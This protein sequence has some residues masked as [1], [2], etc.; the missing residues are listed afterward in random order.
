MHYKKTGYDDETKLYNKDIKEAFLKQFEGNTLDTMRGTLKLLAKAERDFD[1]DMCEMNPDEFSETLRVFKCKTLKSMITRFSALCSYGEWCF[2]GYT[3]GRTPAT[4]EFSQDDLLKYIHHV[5][6]FMS[7]EEVYNEFGKVSINAQ[8]LASALLSWEGVKGQRNCELT[9]LKRQD[10]HPL[11]N[12]IDCRDENDE[13]I[14]HVIVRDT[15]MKVVIEAMNQ[16]EYKTKRVGKESGEPIFY[17]LPYNGFVFRQQT[18]EGDKRNREDTDPITWSRVNARIKNLAIDAG[19]PF[20]TTSTLFQSGMLHKVLEIEEQ[21]G[22]LTVDDYKEVVTSYGNAEST[23]FSLKQLYLSR[24]NPD[25]S[26][27]IL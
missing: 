21:K 8:D 19:R 18:T 7:Y 11:T 24:F 6:N 23:Y 17:A 22:F 10:V 14:R 12:T 27:K 13:V 5:E 9:L 3:N 4:Q 15:T 25:S 20:V 26:D 2:P 16:T 1:K